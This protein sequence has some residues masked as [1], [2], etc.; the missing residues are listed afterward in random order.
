M[1]AG[2]EKSGPTDE[3]GERMHQD[4]SDAPDRS[5]ARYDSTRNEAGSRMN[6]LGKLF[7]PSLRPDVVP[8]RIPARCATTFECPHSDPADPLDP[9]ASEHPFVVDASPETAGSTDEGDS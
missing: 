3:R 4:A 8:Q 5:S 2:P 7:L 6:Y 9:E 1:D